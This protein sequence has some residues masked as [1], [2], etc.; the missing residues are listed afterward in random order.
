M[1]STVVWQLYEG[2]IIMIIVMK[3]S[4]TPDDMSRIIRILEA[5]DL[6][7]CMR[8]YRYLK[9]IIRDLCYRKTNSVY[10]YR[11]LFNNVF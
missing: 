9:K 7:Q 1:G 8:Y 4:A 5:H 10:G 3:P 11:T 2:D 6:I